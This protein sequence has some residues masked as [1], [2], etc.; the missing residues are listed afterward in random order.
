MKKYNHESNVLGCK[1]MFSVYHPPDSEQ[2]VVP[3]RGVIKDGSAKDGA[4]LV[5]DV[6][7]YG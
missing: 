7:A 2:G 5:D 6:H 4:C 3:V 1:M